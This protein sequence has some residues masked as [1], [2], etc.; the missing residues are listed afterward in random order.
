VVAGTTPSEVTVVLRIATRASELALR[1]ARAVQAMLMEWGAESELVTFRTAGDRK[2]EDTITP[3]SAKT[4]FTRELEQALVKRQVELAVH[5]LSDM[6]TDAVPG[7]VIGAIPVR[8]DP[9]D[10]LV[11]SR[12]L[13]ATPL[14]EL[15]RG[16]RIGAS[17]VRCR[18][19]LRAM[20]PDLEVVHLRGDLPTRLHKVDE[21]QVHGAVV[22]AAALHRLEITQRVATYLEPP[23]W[24]P[25]AA[26]GA[27]AVQVREDDASLRD[28]VSALDDPRVH[29]AVAAERALLAALEGNLQSPLGALALES[30]GARTLHGM[31]ADP[32]GRQVL[33][34]ELDMNGAD[35]ELVGVRVA[36]ELRANGG[37]RILDEL[38]RATHTPSP[39]PDA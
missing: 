31:I 28:I 17:S 6:S 38:R 27:I 4:I 5:A 11:F 36:N 9:R 37:N 21:G 39:Q 1:R 2:H 13:E 25:A 14:D 26:Q 15:P 8:D 12:L 33:R 19:F 24:L 7:L 16:S 3:T 34:A 29:G 10:V 23:R 22:P 30:N 32:Q 20:F 35:P 18:A